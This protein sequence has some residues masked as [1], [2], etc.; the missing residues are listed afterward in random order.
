MICD[1]LNDVFCQVIKNPL[2]RAYVLAVARHGVTLLGGILVAHGYLHNDDVS[3]FLGFCTTVVGIYLAQLDVKGV[4][5]KIKDAKA[6]Q[7]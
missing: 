3:D 5:V 1:K 6:E 2:T 7:P 4:D